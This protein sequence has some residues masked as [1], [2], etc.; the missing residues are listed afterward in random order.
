MCDIY[1]ALHTRYV[2]L[3][4]IGDVTGKNDVYF[5][6]FTFLFFDVFIG[7]WLLC[8]NLVIIIFILQ[9]KEISHDI[10][11]LYYAV[12]RIDEYNLKN[13]LFKKE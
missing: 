12:K 6:D 1:V 8:T 7:I 11:Y 2:P 5:M 10:D 3:L 9:L 4:D 13:E